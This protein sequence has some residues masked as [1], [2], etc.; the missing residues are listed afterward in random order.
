MKNFYAVILILFFSSANHASWITALSKIGKVA[1]NAVAASKTAAGAKGAA[2]TGIA[3][4][5]LDDAAKAAKLNLAHP[6][7]PEYETALILNNHYPWASTRLATCMSKSIAMINNSSLAYCTSQYQKCI[8]DRK[9]KTTLE[10][11]NEACITQTNK[12]YHN[13]KK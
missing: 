7:L 2:A 5:E 1:D 13:E 11:P 10:T 6:V 9:I 4:N 12:E 8:D 3:V